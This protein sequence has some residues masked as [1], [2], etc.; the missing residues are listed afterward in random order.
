MYNVSYA[1]KVAT[2]SQSQKHK[3]EL[4][5][6]NPYV[7]SSVPI[8]LTDDHIEA[9][10]LEVVNQC[11]DQKDLSPGAVYIGQMS[12]T[13]ANTTPYISPLQRGQW[14]GGLVELTFKLLVD[15]ETDT[16]ERIPM[17]FYD[18][19]SATW[20]ER[21]VK[22]VA[23]D[24]MNRFDKLIDTEVVFGIPWQ[25][26]T[27]ICQ[28]CGV[29]YGQAATDIQNYPNANEILGLYPD[30]GI[31]TYREMLS[32]VVQ[33]V[34]G[35][36]T[37]GRD[38]KLYVKRFNDPSM[39]VDTFDTDQRFAGSKF[40]D[41]VTKYTH[42]TDGT[43]EEGLVYEWGDYSGAT[44]A[45]GGNPFLMYGD[46]DARNKQHR[47]I[48]EEIRGWKYVPFTTT[49]L[50]GAEY[51][52][53]DILR[54]VGGIAGTL[55]V[56]LVNKI[57]WKYKK[58]FTISGFGVNPK[59]TRL[60]DR[61]SGKGSAKSKSSALDYFRIKNLGDISW[62]ADGYEHASDEKTVGFIDFVSSGDNV[63]EFW[64]QVQL[65]A[66]T[67]TGAH[68]GAH[69]RTRAY[70]DNELVA[71]VIDTL[72]TAGIYDYA[73]IPIYETLLGSETVEA[74]PHRIEFTV[75]ILDCWEDPTW[76]DFYIPAG[77]FRATLKGH[78]LKQEKDWDGNFKYE[79]YV[80]EETIKIITPDI[81]DTFGGI[82]MLTPMPINLVDVGALD[83]DIGI[84]TEGLVEGDFALT[85][86][87]DPKWPICGDGFIMNN[88]ELL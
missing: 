45:L 63:A 60:S 57:V 72:T 26:V 75:Q 40:S 27:A 20:T 62:I 46:E 84:K 67:W 29:A 18:I 87:L 6:S 34:G 50:C 13:I 8:T 36:A 79:D 82:A 25:I 1:Y 43:N 70:M 14:V 49:I 58:G 53:G 88:N 38:G 10:T 33:C 41:Y 69:I 21:G 16:W 23:Y 66:N 39:A 5:L 24:F 85:K 81:T 65:H 11:S 31:T 4:R 54:F 12:V 71:E 2:H 17:G 9:G 52:L 37:V 86:S 68:Q 61:S 22:I 77:G 28:A 59:I 78:G 74:K 56:G 55:S 83:Q 15:E 35:F 44:V 51:D 32:A 30:S 19:A 73:D 64:T 47:A 76:V 7:A 3:I 42:L 80:S 48:L